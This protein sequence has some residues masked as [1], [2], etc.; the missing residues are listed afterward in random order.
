MKIKSLFIKGLASA[1]LGCFLA[2]S[3]LAEEW[4]VRYFG[5]GI[6]V[7]DGAFSTFFSEDFKNKYWTSSPFQAD[8]YLSQEDREGAAGARSWVQRCDRLLLS[9]QLSVVLKTLDQQW[10]TK[11]YH[12]R[13]ALAC[14]EDGGLMFGFAPAQFEHNTVPARLKKRHRLDLAEIGFMGLG[15]SAKSTKEFW[16]ALGKDLSGDEVGLSF[17]MHLGG[18]GRYNVSRY[19]ITVSLG[20]K[21]GP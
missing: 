15:G 6:N 3:A 17:C 7:Y 14:R 20:T 9:H 11:R 13:A 2:G 1:C 12:L 10:L 21:K 18:G 4:R 5:P 8:K 19:T 16:T